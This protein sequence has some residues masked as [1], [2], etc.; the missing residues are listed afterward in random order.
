[1]KPKTLALLVAGVVGILFIGVSG[2]IAALSS[3]IFPSTTLAEGLASDFSATSHI[4][5]RLR[6]IHPILSIA[7]GVFLVFL[8]NRL[9]LQAKE[10][11]RIN[12]WANVLSVLVLIQ[13]ASGA[14]TLLAHAPILMQI[15]HLFLADSLWI[16]F[17]LLSANVLAEES[18]IEKVSFPAQMQSAVS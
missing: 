8:A 18:E 2:S 10:N 4:L 1:M 12:R 16:A 14:I 5:L 9:K 15:I 6:I 3:M 13:F 11:V 7:V 17:I